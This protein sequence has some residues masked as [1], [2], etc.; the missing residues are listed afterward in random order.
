MGVA[1]YCSQ[2]P[3]YLIYFCVAAGRAQKGLLWL[4]TNNIISYHMAVATLQLVAKNI[5]DMVHEPPTQ[6]EDNPNN[7]NAQLNARHYKFCCLCVLKKVLWGFLWLLVDLG[8]VLCCTFIYFDVYV[9]FV[10]TLQKSMC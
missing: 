1:T 7:L 8:L 9:R 3:S 2:P 5:Q 6:K 4:G 10:G